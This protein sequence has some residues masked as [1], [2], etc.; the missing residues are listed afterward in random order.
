MATPTTFLTAQQVARR[1]AIIGESDT[2]TT[3][4]NSQSIPSGYPNHG[5]NTIRRRLTTAESSVTTLQNSV[6]ASNNT[7]NASGTTLWSRVLNHDNRLNTLEGVVGNYGEQSPQGWVRTAGNWGSIPIGTGA[8]TD[9]NFTVRQ[10]VSALRD[11]RNIVVR[12]IGIVSTPFMVNDSVET[13]L[14]KLRCATNIYCNDLTA[15][16]GTIPLNF[17]GN[18]QDGVAFALSSNNMKMSGTGAINFN[19]FVA[20]ENLTTRLNK[21]SSGGVF[22]RSHSSWSTTANAASLR[23]SWARLGHVGI[24]TGSVAPSGSVNNPVWRISPPFFPFRTV[25]GS[26]RADN[27]S[28]GTVSY[29]M[30]GDLTMVGFVT[31]SNRASFQLIFEIDT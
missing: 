27:N 8:L 14:Q 24:L 13:N 31:S 10:R 1:L 21:L 16:H 11:S 6:G 20:N 19:S 15:N 23:L 29:A 25:Y 9:T 17:N 30:N 22:T 4:N 7:A 5:G 3:G 18:I 12:N 28:I 26:W 2:D